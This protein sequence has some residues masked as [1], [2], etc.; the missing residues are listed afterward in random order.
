MKLWLYSHLVDSPG[1]SLVERELTSRGHEF[2][3]LRPGDLHLEL[4]KRPEEFPDL[5]FPRIGSSAPQSALVELA[6]LERMG[7][8]CVNSSLALAASRD[9]ALAQAALEQAGVPVP[10]SVWLGKGPLDE[11]VA[12]LPGPPWVLKLTLGTKGQGVALVESLRSLRSTVDALRATNVPLLLQEFVESAGGADTRV[13]VLGGKAV[14]GARRQSTQ[15]EEFRSNVALGG[16][17]HRV[18]LDPQWGAI[19]EQA[20]NAVGL[21]VAGVDLV[22]GPDGPLVLE[23]NGSPGLAA[24][25][26][27]PSLL[28]DYLEGLL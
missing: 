23:V 24:A 2:V 3:R 11:V 20:S 7:Y 25:P 12:R 14:L 18:E 16:K 1:N 8:R 28:V 6:L 17:A 19:A 13:I 26:E 21:S 9:K 4:G 22:Q 5:L 15:S 10:R 27:M